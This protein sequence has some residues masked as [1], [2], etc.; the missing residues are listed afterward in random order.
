MAEWIWPHTPA[1]RPDE[2]LGRFARHWDEHGYGPWVWSDDA[3]GEVVGYGGP[4]RTTVE[5]V[6]AVEVLYAV[7]SPRW[8]EGLATEIARESVRFAFDDLG[9]ERLVCFTRTDNVA[10]RRVMEK[11]GFRYERD[12]ERAGMQHALCRITRTE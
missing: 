10:S 8:G 12:F 7:A 4:H 11:A 9:L 3:T 1:P 5:G 6:E 2:L